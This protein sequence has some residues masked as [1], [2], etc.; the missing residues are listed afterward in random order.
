MLNIYLHTFKYNYCRHFFAEVFNHHRFLGS[1]LFINS[2][3]ILSWKS[4][5][6]VSESLHSKEVSLKTTLLASNK[7]IQNLHQ[8]I[9]FSITSYQI[10][11]KL[12]IMINLFH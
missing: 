3:Y 4:S 7:V 1:D 9:T 6:S 2:C 12:K 5:I 11:Q 8:N 10:E